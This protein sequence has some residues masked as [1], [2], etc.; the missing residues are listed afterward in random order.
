M[1]HA[2]RPVMDRRR[3]FLAEDDDTL[4]T[5]VAAI[6]RAAGYHVMEAHDGLELLAGIEFAITFQH[7]RPEHL[8]VVSDIE[9]PGLSGLDV[10]TI[11]HCAQ[12]KTACIL[13]TGFGDRETVAEASDLGA[14]IFHKPFDIDDL[15]TTVV[16][17]APPS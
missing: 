17:L 12:L 15:V 8:I 3:V 5:L 7:E 6:L 14:R 9:M 11:L 13:I 16:E 1:V 10:L 4:R 2:G